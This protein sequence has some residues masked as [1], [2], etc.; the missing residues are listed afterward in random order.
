ME[1]LLESK[2]IT[3]KLYH[4]IGKK[5]QVIEIVSSPVYSRDEAAD[6]NYNDFKANLYIDS[7]FM[8]EISDLLDKCDAWMDIIDS[9]DWEEMFVE[10]YHDLLDSYDWKAA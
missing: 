8:A 2:I 10:N 3:M 5:N 7:K 6:L 4:Q 9:V 1:R